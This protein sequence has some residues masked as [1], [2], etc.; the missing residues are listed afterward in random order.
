MGIFI[1][2]NG[3]INIKSIAQDLRTRYCAKIWYLVQEP[4]ST[5]TLSSILVMTNLIELSISGIR[6]F[7]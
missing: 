6:T 4:E 3:R 1:L 2:A 7:R 5:A